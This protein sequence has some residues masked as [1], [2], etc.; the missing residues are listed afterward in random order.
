MRVVNDIDDVKVG[1]SF[2]C[3]MIVWELLLED[4]EEAK[5]FI[6]RRDGEDEFSC[7][8]DICWNDDDGLTE[9]LYAA[10]NAGNAFEVIEEGDAS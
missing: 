1:E 5:L 7:N 2:R 6:F 4:E 10:S 9:F 8:Q 3:P